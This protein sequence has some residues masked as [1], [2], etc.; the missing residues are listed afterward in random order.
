MRSVVDRFLS[1]LLVGALLAVNCLALTPGGI[2]PAAA[3]SA[4][5]TFGGYR[6][7][8][9]NT[10]NQDDLDMN[11]VRAMV[12]IPL[13]YNFRNVDAGT[14]LSVG[15]LYG[16][17]GS[18]FAQFGWIYGYTDAAHGFAPVVRPFIGEYAP[19]NPYDEILKFDFTRTLT[20]GTSHLFELRRSED[21]SSADY[22]KFFG[23]IDGV[24]IL[25]TQSAHLIGYTGTVG[26]VDRRCHGLRNSVVQNLSDGTLAPTL[27]YRRRST[28][29]WYQWG[30][31]FDV[32]NDACFT[33]T[34]YTTATANDYSTFAAS[35][36]QS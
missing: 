21:A 36:P 18:D 34:R 10:F 12:D 11:G 24:A 13:T 7:G 26:E 35:C 17:Y 23:F 22:G 5:C 14:D 16:A 30:V 27:K 4:D 8:S 1:R 15:D 20:P 3:E 28:N 9:N 2:R 25:K 33:A 31:Q 32:S 19:G 6:A 29:T